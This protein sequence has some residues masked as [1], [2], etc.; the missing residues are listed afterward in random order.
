MRTEL[1]WVIAGLE[2]KQRL[3]AQSAVPFPAAGPFPAWQLLALLGTT[4]LLVLGKIAPDLASR[5][6]SFMGN[7]S[8]G[9][10]NVDYSTAQVSATDAV[11][12]QQA[13]ATANAQVADEWRAGTMTWD[14]ADQGLS[15]TR[16]NWLDPATQ[17]YLAGAW[18]Q[19]LANNPLEPCKYLRDKAEAA[20]Q[21][22]GRDIAEWANSPGQQGYFPDGVDSMIAEDA[23]AAFCEKPKPFDLSPLE[24]RWIRN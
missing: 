4:G 9:A 1:D 14:L 10:G 23:L 15:F 16:G 19:A 6:Q 22:Y 21:Q 18:Q 12:I 5:L 20:R 24:D 7:S 2:K 8:S 13:I 3:Q 17:T 11:A